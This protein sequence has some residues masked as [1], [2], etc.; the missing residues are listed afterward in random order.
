MK[1]FFFG[2]IF[3]CVS[4][5]WAQQPPTRKDTLWNF[6]HHGTSDSIKLE[7]YIELVGWYYI[8][9]PDSAV[10][11]ANNALVLADQLQ[12]HLQR[13]YS[14][15]WLAYLYEQMSKMDLALD[16]NIE[17][18]ES[19]VAAGDTLG[20]SISLNNIGLVY[21]RQGD[22]KNALEYWEKS[23]VLAQQINYNSGLGST[24]G[25]IGYMYMEQGDDYKAIEY[26]KQSAYFNEI[27]SN[28]HGLGISYTNIG[29]IYSRQ[30]KYEDAIQY[31]QKSLAIKQNVKDNVVLVGGWTNLGFLYS[32]LGEFNA[33][34]EYFNK[35][36]DLAEKINKPDVVA[37][38]YCNKAVLE[39]RKNNFE[40][41]MNYGVKSLELAHQIRYPSIIKKTQNV[42]VNI[43][44]KLKLL[45]QVDGSVSE[46]LELNNKAVLNNFSMLTE[47]EKEIYFNSLSGEFQTFYSYTLFRKNDK[48]ELTEKVYNSILQNKG[49]LLKSSTATRMAILNSKDSALIAEYNSW[50]KVKKELLQKYAVGISDSLLEKKSEEM[51]RDLVQK[52]TAFSEEFEVKKIDW[53]TVQSN[54]Q[55]HEA[56]IEIIHFK[57]EF[58]STKASAEVVYCALIVK[59]D[60]RHPEMIKLCNEQELKK[61]LGNFPGNNL[62]YIE[63]LYGTQSV[64]QDTLYKL[65]WQPLEKSLEGVSKVFISP[66]GLLH[67]ISFAGLSKN[68]SVFL[69]DLYDIHMFSST[70]QILNKNEELINK[71]S[72]FTLFGGIDYNTE[73]NS[74]EVWTYLEGTKSE[75]N[76]IKSLL[77]NKKSNV[78]LFTAS[79]ATEQEFKTRACESEVLHIA[80]HGFFYPEPDFEEVDLKTETD[81][82]NFRGTNVGYT[83]FVE[84]KNPMMR[85]GLVF[86]GANKVWN[87]DQH[88]S[89][90]DGVV[91]AQEVAVL[92]M[93][94]T[95]L[96][97]LSACETGLGDIKGTE[98]VYGL[99]RSF[100]MAGVRYIIMSLWKVADKETS[101]FMITFYKN[102]LKLKNV[103]SAFNTTQ[104]IMRS[105]YDPYYWAAFVLIE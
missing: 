46:I 8:S 65:I 83:S 5:S 72:Q 62:K 32:E 86:A 27:D 38:I 79:N 44:Y 58:D 22:Y 25:N 87:T 19:Y 63:E 47:K 94:N 67:R 16:A 29:T 93:R 96:V 35:A 24:Y 26:L 89:T 1:Q 43:Y 4:L 73:T 20:V 34:D 3:F 11:I 102:L 75:T 85:S 88:F 37:T 84:N 66:S 33:A 81:E 77:E 10:I 42:M 103:R 39:F 49:F 59:P 14:Y 80:T 90:E 15:G 64:L 28:F 48:P 56:A 13:A 101:E 52:S 70:A 98:G 54:L 74:K 82:L 53:K 18:M 95:A 69:C 7:S 60:S 104:K 51:E 21:L 97:V 50:L 23:L 99:Q 17:A 57:H 76:G 61:I 36:I 91:T 68:K 6:V 2:V 9:D 92:D 30:K 41:A 71:Q 45:D 100:K 12:L 31:I 105:K 78:Q 40:N 55:P